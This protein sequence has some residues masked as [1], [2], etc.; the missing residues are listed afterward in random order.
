MTN[1]YMT[2][3]QYG[4]LLKS[5]PFPVEVPNGVAAVISYKNCPL[6]RMPHGYF[7][8]FEECEYCHSVS[9]EI[10][11]TRLCCKKCGAPITASKPFVQN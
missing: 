5:L 10:D 4:K 9:R 3:E 1:Q 2:I 8:V 7:V 11:M 6:I